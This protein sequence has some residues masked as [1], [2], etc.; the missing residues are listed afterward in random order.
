MK[1][2]FHPLYTLLKKLDSS[3]NNPIC[4]IK[5]DIG[6]YHNNIMYMVVIFKSSSLT[7]HFFM[8]IGEDGG[9]IDTVCW[10]W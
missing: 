6:F 3:I 8:F 4:F 10:M 2:M 9:I 7:L 1:F 5:L